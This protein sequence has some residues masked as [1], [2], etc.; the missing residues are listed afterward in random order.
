MRL[1]YIGKDGAFI[2]GEPASDHDEPDEAKY[3]EKLGSTIYRSESGAEI[4]AAEAVA[5]KAKT[6]AN[7]KAAGDLQSQAADAR[8]EANSAARAAEAAGKKAA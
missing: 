7:A 4:R 1:I 5:K 8:S 6:A 2:P 3:Q